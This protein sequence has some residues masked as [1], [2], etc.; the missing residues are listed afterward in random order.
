MNISVPCQSG[1]AASM[2]GRSNSRTCFSFKKTPRCVRY[3]ARTSQPAISSPAFSPTCIQPAVVK[4]IRP[5]QLFRVQDSLTKFVNGL[6]NTFNTLGRTEFRVL[7]TVNI[8]N[9]D[10]VPGMP[11]VPGPYRIHPDIKKFNSRKASELPPRISCIRRTTAPFPDKIDQWA[12]VSGPC[13]C[14]GP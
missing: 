1:P 12:F 11:P 7:D 4:R 9:T 6:Q 13:V 3:P 5:E 14:F 8:R 2:K 10:F